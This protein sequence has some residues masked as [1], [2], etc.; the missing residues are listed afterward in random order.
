MVDMFLHAGAGLHGHRYSSQRPDPS[1]RTDSFRPHPPKRYPLLRTALRPLAASD[2]HA[3]AEARTDSSTEDSTEDSSR[4]QRR[5]SLDDGPRPSS[6]SRNNTV[7]GTWTRKD[8]AVRFREPHMDH[9]RTPVASEDEDSLAGSQ[10]SDGTDGSLQRARRKRAPRRSTRFA[11]AH[12]APQ[13]RTK[14]RMLIQLRPRLLLQL[15]EVGDRRAIPAFDVVPSSLVAGTLI[16]PMLA[17]RFP[18]MFRSKAELGT[19]DVLV[20]RSDDYGP[21]SAGSSFASP[22]PNRDADG[23]DVLAVISP[24]PQADACAEIVLEDGS[25]WTA[26]LVAGGSYEFTHVEDDGSTTTAR[27]VRRS[28]AATRNSSSSL[29]PMLPGTP[30]P[31]LADERRWT[32]SI[33]DPST[34]RHPILGCLTPDMAEIYDTYTTLSTAS[35]RYPPSRPFGTD[36]AQRE[37]GSPSAGPRDERTTVAVTAAHK[38]LMLATATWIGLQRQGWPAS[39]NP[40][41]SRAVPHCRAVSVGSAAT[42]RQTFPPDG[43]PRGSP[44]PP[45]ADGL[46]EQPAAHHGQ[47]HQRSAVPARTM[48]TGRAFMKQRLGRAEHAAGQKRL[49]SLSPRMLSRQEQEQEPDEKTHACRPK[50]RTWLQRLFHL[51]RGADK[52][53]EPAEEMAKQ[54]L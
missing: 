52:D 49:S 39:A 47:P 34:R 31:P 11:F 44:S 9:V 29:G 20:V 23:R 53:G 24:T 1:Q 37:P 36:A 12:P 25:T 15:Q 51:R 41:F 8:L 4:Q 28:S 27:W 30:P 38:R 13:L 7:S 26:D 3:D 42:R 50:I 16:I 46:V 6:L 33:I 45:S 14:Q 54:S 2:A 32:F 10:L 21:P 35:G 19:D 40:K 18:R 22:S 5:R 48:S 43:S 17:K